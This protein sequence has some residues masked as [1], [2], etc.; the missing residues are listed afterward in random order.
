MY[1]QLR[2]KD[3]LGKLLDHED[4][5]KGDE[6][7]VS[8]GITTR[9]LRND[10]KVLNDLLFPAGAYVAQYVMAISLLLMRLFDHLINGNSFFLDAAVCQ[11]L[12]LN[13]N[14]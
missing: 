6:L 10:V 5:L 9:T 12:S 3:I 7:A 13:G 8:I 2:L 1:I 14:A 4:N 11:F